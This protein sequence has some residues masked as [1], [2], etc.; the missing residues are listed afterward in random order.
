MSNQISYGDWNSF[1][2]SYETKTHSWRNAKNE[3]FN[4][5]QSNAKKQSGSSNYYGAAAKL[6]LSQDYVSEKSASTSKVYTAAASTRTLKVGTSGDDVK[7]L[8]TNLNAL[9]YNVGTPDGIFGTNTKN[10]VISFQNT[11]GLTADGIAGTNT[12]NAISRTISLK[13]SNILSKGQ[14]SNDVKNL[15]NNLI[16]LGYLS[17]TADGAFG[18][19]TENA[20]I[21]FQRNYGLTA[22][23]LVGDATK[24]KLAQ[25]LSTPVTPS[26]GNYT[27]ISNGKTM[28][29][30][31]PG[32]KITVSIGTDKPS[33]QATVTSTN[34][35]SIEYSIA[36][37]RN[38]YPNALCTRRLNSALDKFSYNAGQ[39]D[40]LK[41]DVPGLGTCYAG[42]MVDG[43]GQIG[44]VAE[45]TLDNGTKFNFMILDTKSTRHTSAE[46]SPNNQCQNEWGHGYMM[47]NN[48]KVQLNVC[49]F[50]TS[51]SISGAGS[52]TRYPSGSFLDG[53][54]VTSAKI[55]GHAN[56]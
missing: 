5:G 42:A 24:N 55:I 11:Y 41:L 37:C 13:N 50:I 44:D 7:A 56:I 18:K 31:G 32:S 21:A 29:V 26:T 20:V 15:Q 14:V 30:P 40:L 25:V 3:A 12:L 1:G 17:G 8:Q 22:D 34:C 35:W 47:S 33:L 19:N 54:Y 28:N 4:S 9:G 10:A 36:G 39:N 49:E 48:T 27:S 6:E 51:Q 43:F 45:V 23:G 38:A 53:R 46:L 16:S 2:K 52:A